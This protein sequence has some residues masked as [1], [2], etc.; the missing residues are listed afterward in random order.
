MTVTA[1]PD[2]RDDDLHDVRHWVD[3][4]AYGR[5]LYDPDATQPLQ[6]LRRPRVR[7]D[8]DDTPTWAHPI[9]LMSAAAAALIALAGWAWAQ[10]PGGYQEADPTRGVVVARNTDVCGRDSCFAFPSLT[11]RVNTPEGWEDRNLDFPVKDWRL[12]DVHAN[13]TARCRPGSAVTIDGDRVT[14]CTPIDE[15]AIKSTR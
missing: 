14:S 13:N 10:P 7:D 12:R 4:D 2:T 11:V 6:L 5:P 1:P 3:T 9:T 15:L 8:V